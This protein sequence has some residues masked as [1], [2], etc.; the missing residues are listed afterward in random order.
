MNISRNITLTRRTIASFLAVALLSACGSDDAASG[1]EADAPAITV[2]DT[3]PEAIPVATGEPEPVDLVEPATINVRLE[4]V[5]GI[6]SEGFEIGLRFE[7][8]TGEVI[9]STLW[10]D[11]VNAQE[12][13]V[14]NAFYDS[15]L[16][17]RV[18]AGEV[19]VLATANVGIGPPPEV[20]DLD[21]DLRC[22]LVVD[23][24]AD[25]SVDVVVTF[26]GESDCL[27]LG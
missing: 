14:P 18:P 11:F 4:E 12:D 22:Q 20:P 16:E 13:P 8:A 7:T 15:V 10:S 23:V 2:G 21:G 27:E 26:S 17:Q 3:L 1:D 5:D 9:D 24:A 19:L 6:F 25:S